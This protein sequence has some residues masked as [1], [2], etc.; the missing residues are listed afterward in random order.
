MTSR[1]QEMIKWMVENGYSPKLER[2]AIERFI[3]GTLKE[4]VVR[5]EDALQVAV[6]LAALV[7]GTKAGDDMNVELRQILQLRKDSSGKFN[8]DPKTEYPGT[9]AYEIVKQHLRGEIKRVEAVERF[10]MEV[11]GDKSDFPDTRTIERWIDVMKPRVGKDLERL[12]SALSSWEQLKNQ[13]TK[14]SDN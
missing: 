4:E 3:D 6:L 10:A 5:H 11:F 1:S 13:R 8:F 9:L 12:D 7:Q 14:N 2:E